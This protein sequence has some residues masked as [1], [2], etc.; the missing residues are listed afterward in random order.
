MSSESWII[1]EYSPWSTIGSIYLKMQKLYLRG[2]QDSEEN[3][4]EN[5][6][7]LEDQMASSDSPRL[8][9]CDSAVCHGL[10]E[11]LIV[12]GS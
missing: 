10:A 5:V 2:G 12:G 7:K 9:K 6:F 8:P 11:V 4:K 3:R 1:L